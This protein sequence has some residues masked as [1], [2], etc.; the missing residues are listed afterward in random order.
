[1]IKMDML[2]MVYDMYI[3]YELVAYSQLEII[4]ASLKWSIPPK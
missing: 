1:M 2:G 4:W 3:V